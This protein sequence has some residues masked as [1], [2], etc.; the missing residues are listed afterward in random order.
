MSPNATKD[1]IRI[2]ILKTISNA[3][4]RT[5]FARIKHKKK[6]KLRKLAKKKLKTNSNTPKNLVAPT[7]RRS[8]INLSANFLRTKPSILKI[9]T[10]RVKCYPLIMSAQSVEPNNLSIVNAVNAVHRGLVLLAIETTTRVIV[11]HVS[12][13]KKTRM[14]RLLM[15]AV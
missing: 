13:L 15:K 3:K 1:T 2:A 11:L 7:T 5:T 9:T 10:H 14:T 8:R 6:Q 12:T 4:K